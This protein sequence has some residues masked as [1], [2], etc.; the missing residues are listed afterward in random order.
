MTIGFVLALL[1]ALIGVSL[2]VWQRWPSDELHGEWFR[3]PDKK[4]YYIGPKS[5]AVVIR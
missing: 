3:Q 2:F 1:L 5:M 4:G